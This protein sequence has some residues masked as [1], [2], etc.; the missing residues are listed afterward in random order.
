MK[1]I[2]IFG[3]LWAASVACIGCS[4][5]FLELVPPTQNPIDEYFTTEDHVY[6]AL[7]A[8]YD[9]LHWPD[10]N[11][12][13]YCPVNIMSDI[14]ADDIWV[15]GSD[16]NDNQFWHLMMNYNAN[17]NNCMS[18][19]WTCEYSG[20]KRS[21]DVLL[22]LEWAGNNVSE[23]N[24]ASW[25]AQARVLR[26]YYYNNLW[27]FWGN[28]PFY[29]E[30]LEYPYITEQVSADS[31][32][33]A[34]IADLED[35]INA[36]ALPMKWE[37]TTSE[38]NVGKVSQ[39][40]A[41]MLYTEMVM[42]QND[43]SR[44]ATALGYMQEIIDDSEYQLLSSYSTIF[45]ESGEWGSESIFE[46]NY[47]SQ[48]AVR[49][50]SGPLV[51]GGTCLP[52]L[53]TPYAFSA[54]SGDNCG[55][56][57]GWGFAPIRLETYE[58]FSD[59]DERRDVT[60]FDANAHGTYE[61]RYQDTGYFLGKYIAKTANLDG[62]LADGDLNFNNNLRVYRY[63]ETLLNAAELL[64]RTGG[65]TGL[66]ST[67]LNEVHSRA[68]LTDQVSPTIDNIINERRLEF[69]GE[70]K[71][72]WDL[73]RTEKAASTLIP[74]DYGYRT[75]TWSENKKYLPIPQSEIDAAQGTLTQNDY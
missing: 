70:G 13:Q 67:Y 57:Q 17:P 53:I 69:V 75:N 41:Y 42:Y 10:W 6:E 71:R 12:E 27:K 37:D 34:I 60:C 66:A 24:Q 33:N 46:I 25:D 5:D 48:N 40:M 1:T 19:L 45:E 20:V 61:A 16:R 32:Y 39:A 64:V 74:D 18:G 55:V 11:G 58:M 9:P 52:R 8:A 3:F 2:K 63:A 65:N 47:K 29:M 51:A 21:N 28:L 49:S 35:V 50:Y 23:E 72:Y 7:V 73:V 26:A 31:V 68:G 4:D 36:G 56:D 43:E 30:N 62:Q 22:Y 54:N 14:M 38:D 59:G 44:Y 15:G